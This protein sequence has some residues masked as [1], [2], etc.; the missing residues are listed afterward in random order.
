MP[1]DREIEL[2]TPVRVSSAQ[3]KANMSVEVV[4]HDDFVALTTGLAT[5]FPKPTVGS[6]VVFSRSGPSPLADCSSARPT[7]LVSSSV[8]F[9]S[10]YE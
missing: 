9:G 5:P 3:R 6:L 1:A 8:K 7:G 4:S 10:E 2:W